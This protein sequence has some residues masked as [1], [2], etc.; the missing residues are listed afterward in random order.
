MSTTTSIPQLT[1][2]AAWQRKENTL[3]AVARQGADIAIIPHLMLANTKGGSWEAHQAGNAIA[4][5][6]AKLTIEAS[7][8]YDG[9]WLPQR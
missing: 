2:P 3:Y 6:K 9:K 8:R 1:K 7:A 5:R 4:A